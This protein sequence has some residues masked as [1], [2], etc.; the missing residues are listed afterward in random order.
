MIMSGLVIPDL[1]SNR[2]VIESASNK[3]N[4]NPHSC[5]HLNSFVGFALGKIGSAH[6]KRW[7]QTLFIHHHNISISLINCPTLI[8]Y[9]TNYFVEVSQWQHD[10][11]FRH[12]LVD[13]VHVV[14]VDTL[15]AWLSPAGIKKEVHCHD[16]QVNRNS[17]H[18]GA[19][20]TSQYG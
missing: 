3:Q 18:Y 15:R 17:L 6:R 4:L 19:E 11:S 1:W 14:L 13:L 7:K 10:P 9:H 20:T 5:D 8:H 2:V 12:P 16:R